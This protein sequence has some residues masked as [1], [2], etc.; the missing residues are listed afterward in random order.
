M[1]TR[2]WIS[3][4]GCRPHQ[5]VKNVLVFVPMLAAQQT[6]LSSWT[7][8]GLVFIALSAIASGVYLIND[9]LDREA[10]RAHPRKR[11]RPI[12]SGVMSLRH[13]KVLST[14]L[15]VTGFLVALSVGWLAA[16]VSGLYF[17]G[18][19]LYSLKLKERV[20]ID[21]W[22]L[23]GLYTLR[24][25]IGAAA[26]ATAVSTW[27]LAFSLFFFLALAA[28]KRQAEL[29]GMVDEPDRP[30]RRGYR[31]QDRDIVSQMAIAAGYV[32]VLV[33]ALYIDSDGITR[34]YERPSALWGICAIVGFWVSR[35]VMIAHRGQMHDDPI[36]FALK[37]RI[38]Q[39]CGVLS[40]L[41]VVVAL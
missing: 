15:I 34:L 35:A 25:L 30:S 13:A 1:L 8:A 3:L 16:G 33:L 23:A 12:A 18:T 31:P 6:G 10:D 38:S 17:T 21:I 5:W 32:A 24:V 28:M 2:T 14:C 26:T 9:L 39:L 37:D 20:V 40:V 27:L 36:V 41:A 7:A 4:R 29:A 22:V 11:H 19:A